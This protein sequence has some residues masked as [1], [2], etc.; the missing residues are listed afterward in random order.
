MNS[1]A[2]RFGTR[3]AVIASL[4]LVLGTAFGAGARAATKTWN[5]AGGGPWTTAG[6]WTPNGAPLAGD[7]IQFSTGG[8][9]TVTAVPALSIQQLLVSNGSAVT[10]QAG[11]AN[12]LTIVGGPGTDLS[13]P[14]GTQLNVSG[15]T[16]LT[17]ALA[18][19][20]TGS[21]GGS[22]AFSGAAHRLDAASVSAIAFGSG[23]TFTQ[24]TSCTGNVFTST[25]TA[26]VIL[27]ASG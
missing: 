24:G 10:L 14:S 23:A 7:V 5:N 21:I 6:N 9:F 18:S 22:M 16:V 20:A 15:A 25:G 8:T 11:A 26:N 1:S 13:V 17:L 4:T 2:S 19:G 3:L 12:A 27:F